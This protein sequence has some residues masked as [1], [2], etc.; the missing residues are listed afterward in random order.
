M[1]AKHST[2]AAAGR[3]LTA[4]QQVYLYRDALRLTC[5]STATTA[6]T[7][8]VLE[9]TL[10]STLDRYFVNIDISAL[11]LPS[12]FTGASSEVVLTNL[13]LRLEALHQQFAA[14]LPIAFDRGFVRELRIRIPWLKLQSE[15]I[16]LVVDTV[17]LVVSLAPL[18]D[19]PTA[20]GRQSAPGAGGHRA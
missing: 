12:L 14:G 9:R 7:E 4:K 11:K 13:E 10:A 1:G 8:R 18:D 17:E 5:D 6:A 3:P 20:R 2:C 19:L 15:P 16:T